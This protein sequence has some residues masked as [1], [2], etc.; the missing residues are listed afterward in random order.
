MNWNTR[1]KQG[2][3]WEKNNENRT[4]QPYGEKKKEKN[5]RIEV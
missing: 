2:A 5:N 1:L 3:K 4:N